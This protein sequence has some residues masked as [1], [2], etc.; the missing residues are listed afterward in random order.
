[1]TLE[2]HCDHSRIVRFLEQS[3]PSSEQDL[4]EE[5]LE[6]CVSCRETLE[7]ATADP[8][9]WSQAERHL[10]DETLDLQVGTSLG[11]ET[12]VDEIDCGDTARV[13][14]MLAPTD[15]PL[16]LGRLG[17]Y[18][19]A[20]VI[21][22]GGMGVVLK[23]FD[24]ALNRYV[25]IKVLAPHLASS[26]AARRRF[27][28]EAQAAAA[29]VHE[30]VIEIYGVDAAAGL[31]YLAMPYVRGDSL[32]KR[33]A[34]DGP[35][36]LLEILRI[37]MQTAAG[38]AAAHA[39]GLVH[40]DVKPAN[41][42]LS[43][44]VARVTLTDFGLARTVDDASLTYTGVIAGTPQFMSPE[45]ARGD[46]VDH[47][48]DL[49]SLGAVLYTM[50]VGHPPFRAESTYGVLRKLTDQT[51]TAIRELN[52]EI[53]VWLCA[54]VDRLLAK[55][56]LERYQ[57]ADEVRDL[58]NECLAHAQQPTH[59][60]LPPSLK[61]IARESSRGERPA[62]QFRSRLMTPTML[63]IAA[64][65]IGLSGLARHPISETEAIPAQAAGDTH[66]SE[67]A[68][69]PH[70]VVPA[71]ELPATQVVPLE[72]TRISDADNEFAWDDGVDER[73]LH[74]RQGVDA[75]NE[76]ATLDEWTTT[77]IPLPPVGQPSIFPR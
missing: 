5:H 70:G 27:A 63:F 11:S 43:D 52:P 6:T 22:S 18:E 23:G 33:I 49:F 25:A 16:M 46:S 10:P 74:M 45:Q 8:Q 12:S 68:D 58:L 7:D 67:R 55:S 62:K 36:P 47:R 60:P 44:Q 32:Q 48:S 69:D 53:P 72:A 59:R 75:V 66:R 21:G 61:R 65:V 2:T 73:L 39:Q 24:L 37:G 30:N 41:I 17:G 35:L 3:L 40:R 19:I 56:A 28:R 9:W 76:S 64:C 15:D 4:L 50:C 51:P 34:S 13:V 54:L 26:G 42:L 29:V 38:L 20:G 1:M 14:E 77:P 31:P 57:S 71:T